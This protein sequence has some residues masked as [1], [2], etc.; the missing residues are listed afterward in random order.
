MPGP[1]AAS[2]PADNFR[3]FGQGYGICWTTL[4]RRWSSHTEGRRFEPCI[5][6]QTPPMA[7]SAS[8]RP[9]AVRHRPTYSWPNASPIMKMRTRRPMMRARNASADLSR[10]K[11]I[12]KAATAPATTADKPAPSMGIASHRLSES[13]SPPCW[14]LAARAHPISRS[15]TATV[16]RLT[17]SQPSDVR[18]NR[19]NLALPGSPG[20]LSTQQLSS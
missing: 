14:P 15:V 19:R 17:A 10:R 11:E 3:V 13:L 4:R 8:S 6:H 9:S 2:F 18:G 20:L 1:R 7:D 12:A 5:A 16:S